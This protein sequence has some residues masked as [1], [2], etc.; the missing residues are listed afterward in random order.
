M[1]LVTTSADPFGADELCKNCQVRTR[2][3]SPGAISEEKQ[4]VR[5]VERWFVVTPQN[6]TQVKS[7]L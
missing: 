6:E 3:C 1:P 5:G 7:K 4:M 2:A